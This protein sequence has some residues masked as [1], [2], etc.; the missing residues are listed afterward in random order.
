[1][2]IIIVNKTI[3]KSST[4]I[5]ADTATLL[6]LLAPLVLLFW[7]WIE[8]LGMLLLLIINLWEITKLKAFIEYLSNRLG[9]RL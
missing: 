3:L 8:L 5:E 1:M 6:I 4:S 7:I 2:S 9:E